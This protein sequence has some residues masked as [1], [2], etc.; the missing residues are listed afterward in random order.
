LIDTHNVSL[1]RFTPTYGF[2]E[3]QA[4]ADNSTLEGRQQNRRVEIKLLV[5]RGIN[6]NVEVKSQ[7]ADNPGQ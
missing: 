5:S 1:R 7:P 6:Q 2:G 3:L 4:V